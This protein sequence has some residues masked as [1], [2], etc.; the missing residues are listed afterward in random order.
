MTMLEEHYPSTGE[1]IFLPAGEECPFV[2][3]S[4]PA[5]FNL[6]VFCFFFSM[7]LPQGTM[8]VS[9]TLLPAGAG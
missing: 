8:S 5:F 1:S 6:E 3:T 4:L 9:C 7:M 2:P